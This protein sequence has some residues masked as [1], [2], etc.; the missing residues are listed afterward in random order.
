MSIIDRRE[1]IYASLG[2]PPPTA[3]EAA[4]A[5]RAPPRAQ[6]KPCRFDVPFPTFEDV[7]ARIAA[8]VAAEHEHMMVLLAHVIAHMQDEAE[9]LAKVP[10][11]MGPQ[12]V[13]GSLGP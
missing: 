5:D 3:E 4:R 11:P 10:G 7:D 2:V 13:A 6:V 8:A 12:G 9:G 1:E